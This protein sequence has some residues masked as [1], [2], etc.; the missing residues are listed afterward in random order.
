MKII[1]ELRGKPLECQT[2]HHGECACM[3][4]LTHR[5]K[6]QYYVNI[7]ERWK[8][9]ISKVSNMEEFNSEVCDNVVI[10]VEK[11]LLHY[12]SLGLYC[13]QST[14]LGQCHRSHTFQCEP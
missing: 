8:E 9:I 1:T 12:F 11:K 3:M 7:Q 5:N 4:G 13:Q 2:T 6:R 14:I 10:G